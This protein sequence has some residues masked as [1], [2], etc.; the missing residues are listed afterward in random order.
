MTKEAVIPKINIKDMTLIAIMI[1]LLAVSSQFPIPV[2]IGVPITLQTMVVAIIGGILSFRNSFIAVLMY[3]L[4]GAIGVPVFAS[5]TSGI[6]VLAGPSGGFLYAFIVTAPAVA[7]II[8]YL[9]V[10]NLD[11]VYVK[12][13]VYFI[14]FFLI[15]SI[16]VLIIGSY[17]M[18]IVL[19]MN[20]T[21]TL[22]ALV[23]FIP[24]EIIKSI[25]AALIVVKLKKYDIV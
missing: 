11:N 16:L 22:K 3:L 8:K 14:T 13:I 7:L 17:Q 18:M 23:V 6:G 10:D 9:D 24:G 15:T 25:A 1:A 12:Y 21:Q 20:Y 19:G 4:I 2:P 5:F